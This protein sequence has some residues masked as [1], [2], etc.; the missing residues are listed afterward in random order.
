M[1]RTLSLARVLSQLLTGCLV[2]CGTLYNFLQRLL[3]TCCPLLSAYQPELLSYLR[4]DCF[5][6]SYH[7]KSS[8][9]IRPASGFG[10]RGA[11]LCERLLVMVLDCVYKKCNGQKCAK[12]QVITPI[13]FQ[14][15]TL[16]ELL[17]YI[18]HSCRNFI[19]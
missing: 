19:Y 8:P 6:S 11:V 7:L 15:C 16:Q 17:T 9:C 3:T 1:L 18:R 10:S 13:W 5:L 2:K 14:L 4:S 12:G